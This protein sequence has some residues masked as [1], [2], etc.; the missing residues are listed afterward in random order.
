MNQLYT[1]TGKEAFRLFSQT[2]ELFKVGAAKESVAVSNASHDQKISRHAL[3]RPITMVLPTKSNCGPSTRSSK[4]R[5]DAFAVG[6]YG[7][8]KKV[9]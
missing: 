5:S 3:R 7:P 1:C 6:K 2:P 9:S 8:F 4:L